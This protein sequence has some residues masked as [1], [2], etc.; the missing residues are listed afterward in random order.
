MDELRVLSPT[1]ILGYGFPVESFEEGMKRV[2]HVIAVDAGSTDPGPY[3]LGAGKSFTD[4]NSVKRDLEIMIPAALEAGI[5]VIIGTAGGSGARPH[6]ALTLELIKEIANEKGLTFKLAVIQ[7]ELDRELV[8]GKLRKGEV[9]P[10]FPA[11]KLTEKEIDEAVHIVAQMGEEPYIKALD[12]GA[13]VILGGRSYDPSLFAALAIKNGFDKALALHMGKILE[14][15]AIASLPGSGSD[16]MFGYLQ[17]D[18]FI[19]EPL[20]PARKCTPLSV[21]AHTLYEKSNPYVLPGPGGALDLH[22]CTFTPVGDN[23]VKVAGTKFVPTEGYFVKLEGVRKVGYRTISCAGVMDP[24]MIAKIDEITTEVKKRVKNNFEHY[25][26]QE[27]FLDF[28]IYGKGGVSL[29]NTTGNTAE[30]KADNKSVSMPDELLII[31]E[32]VAPTR[33]QANT[34]CG[35]A[36]STLLHHGYEGRVATA[37][38]LAFPFSPSDAEMGE[39]FEFNIYHLMKVDDPVSLF[40]ATYIRF[41]Q[42]EAILENSNSAHVNNSLC[43]KIP[44]I[45]KKSTPN[46]KGGENHAI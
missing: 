12:M 4:N 42:G 20:S 41:N 25:G 37:G 10:L 23:K 16:S 40:P 15:A 13:D 7:S 1:A 21:S 43:S 32:A 24:V 19:L 31:I 45:N 30:V 5:P 44:L 6:V 27:F 2:P 28:K 11:K 17:Q 9:E 8:R 39:V 34:I 36:R 33:E 26:F 3:Y 22:E 35:F 38:N 29:F 18:S 46:E 14:C